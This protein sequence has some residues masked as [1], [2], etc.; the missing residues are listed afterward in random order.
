MKRVTIVMYHFVRDLQHSRYP[1]IKG[2]TLD[3][4]KG[5]IEYIA[6][7]YKP[8]KMEELVEAAIS[9]DAELPP[10][11]ALLTF[12]DGYSDHY[13]N[14]FPILDKRGIQGS[15]FPP[16]RAIVERQ[17]L[18]VNKIHFVLASVQDKS[19]IIEHL[20]N[21]IATNKE[22]FSLEDP[23][24]Y[25]KKLAVPNRYDIADVIFI[26][27][28]LQ[29]ELP[30]AF[31]SEMIDKLFRHFVTQD[32]ASFASELY[33]SHEQLACMRR[34]GMYIGS[35]GYDHY[36]LNTLD[37]K[38]QESEIDKSLAFLSQF[39]CNVEKWVIC[40][41]YGG[42]NDSL[43][44]VLKSRGCRIGLAVDVGIADL[45]RSNPFALPRLD[46]NDLPKQGNAAP[47]EWTLRALTTYHPM[48]LSRPS[49]SRSKR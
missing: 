12:D 32:E 2:L 13:A 23:G 26:K 11:A 47:N 24:Y 48:L 27:R 39:G 7:H 29:R 43:I 37:R 8:I 25:Y 4:F 1:A 3:E 6:K 17:V 18:D 21:E 38:D 46:T 45:Q 19:K 10:N 15:F 16:A 44:S 49:T 42:Y 35:H 28:V 40:Y 36:W 31:R 34:H 9:S 22:R 5:Q 20:N 41:P 33:M 14:V 30:E